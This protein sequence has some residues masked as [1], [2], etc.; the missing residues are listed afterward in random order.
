MKRLKGKCPCGSGNVE[1]VLIRDKRCKLGGCLFIV[2][3]F[4][5]FLMSASALAQSY[6][7]K[8]IKMI[9]PF[10][11]GG[12][13]DV[14]SRIVGQKVSESWGQ[15][16][17]I[18]N[19]PGAGTTIAADFIAKSPSDGY[20]LYFTD[21]TTHAINASLYRKLSYDSLKSFA[22][23]TAV[24]STPLVLVMHP[25]V[26]ATSV[27]E[28]I[29]L[30]KSKPGQL[31]IAHSGI[32]TITHLAGEMF[33]TMA[34]VEMVNIPYT[35]S[36]PATTGILSGEASLLFST[37]PAGLPHVKAGKLRGLA[38]TTP[39][40]VATAPDILTMIEA[41]VPGFEA[42][43]WSGILAPANTP[44]EIISKLNSELRRILQLPDV[45]ERF[46]GQ[47]GEPSPGTPEELGARMKSLIEMWAKVV[48]ASGAKVD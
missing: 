3:L 24:T 42:V 2:A 39:K 27:K 30:A 9:V 47:G 48:K 46:A 16:V 19:R 17:V 21:I 36:A 31:N 38:V 32:G 28:L 22:P 25:S 14:L 43:L 23:V 11:P 40:R 41:G 4:A 33:K 12:I 45:R 20:T 1:T 44:K 29:A 34:G 7:N 6:P 13:S 5:A 8:A 15:P 18:E 35:G 10:P 26:P 37:M